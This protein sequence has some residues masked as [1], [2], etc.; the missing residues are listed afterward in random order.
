MDPGGEIMTPT[1]DD[2]SGPVSSG[3][4][5]PNGYDDG[6]EL[7]GITG[8]FTPSS[9]GSNIGSPIIAPPITPPSSGGTAT[10]ATGTTAASSPWSGIGSTFVDI[11]GNLAK[12]VLPAAVTKYTGI[13]LPGA[14]PGA[15]GSL[16]KTALG[17]PVAAS[18]KAGISV[19]VLLALGV[20]A[21]FLLGRKK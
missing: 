6:T 11:F 8:G 21:Y 15:A 16:P 18:T 4:N 17:A 3:W 12:N 2:S 1:M 13:A 14:V 10:K 19:G 20:G 9:G 7:G 5:V